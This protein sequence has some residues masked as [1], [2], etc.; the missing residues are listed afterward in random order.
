MMPCDQVKVVPPTVDEG[1]GAAPVSKGVPTAVVGVRSVRTRRAKRTAPSMLSNPAPCSKALKPLSGW[2]VYW[3]MTLIIFG[4]SFG[5]A[6]RSSAAAPATMGD[7]TEDP[8]KYICFMLE[9]G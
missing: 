9:V 5:L 8:L 4:V 6:C 7:D 2:A 1:V 3:R